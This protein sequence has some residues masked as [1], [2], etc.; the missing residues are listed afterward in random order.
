MEQKNV[1]IAKIKSI[2]PQTYD[3]VYFADK[4]YP[5]KRYGERTNTLATRLASTFGVDNRPSVLD[6]DVYPEIKLK[7][8]NDHPKMWGTTIVNEL[9]QEIDKDEIGMFC[10]SYNA[11]YHTDILPNLACQIAINS[12][13]EDLDATEELP[14]YGCAAGVYSLNQAV[15]YCQAFDRPAIVFVFDQC[16]IKMKQL[17]PDDKDFNKIL[18]SNLL[19]NDGGIGLLVVPERLKDKFDHPVMK[20]NDIY[21]YHTP[22]H[23]I[24]MTDG[25]FIMDSQLKNVVPKLV[26]EKLIKPILER[27]DLE[28]EDIDEWS[29][30][31]G[32]TKVIKQFSRDDHLGLD[33]EKL[34]PSIEQFHKY[35]NTS[36]SSCLY[37]LE[38]FFNSKQADTTATGSKG[39]L[40]GFGAGYYLAALFYEWS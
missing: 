23:L 24:K 35:G 21:K 17:D 15:R 8:E 32:G 28:I 27:N 9:T 3:A 19:F 11:S 4:V 10:L 6:F 33:E 30:H 16:T 40:V 29:I 12:G 25:K 13:L 37:V 2:F 34:T 31:Q 5:S 22:G 39:L 36:A 7:N 26:S 14:Y 18:V 38:R 1:Y 20:V